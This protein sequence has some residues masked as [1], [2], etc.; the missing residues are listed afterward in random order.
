MVRERQPS[1]SKAFNTPERRVSLL[2]YSQQAAANTADG[3]PQGL[4]K[5]ERKKNHIFKDE[6]L[7]NFNITGVLSSQWCESSFTHE[8]DAVMISYTR[9]TEDQLRFSRII[10]HADSLVQ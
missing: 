4:C 9:L 3:H 8:T 1:P 5:W 6:L 10:F 2:D 7:R